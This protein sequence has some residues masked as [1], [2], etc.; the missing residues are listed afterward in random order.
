MKTK[1][2]NNSGTTRKTKVLLIRS[3][4]T[5]YIDK[6]NSVE[7]Q[8]CSQVLPPQGILHLGSYLK[9][10]GRNIAVEYLDLFLKAETAR[11]RPTSHLEL[12]DLLESHLNT[13][14]K[15][16]PPDIVGLSCNM[17]IYA[18]I[19]HLC[20]GVVKKIFPDSILVAGGHYPSTFSDEVL[21]D[22]NVDT[23]IVGEGELPFLS[24]INKYQDGQKPEKKVVNTGEFI[25]DMGSIPVL[26]Y[27]GIGIKEY[28][29]F[30][31]ERYGTEQIT[32]V[33]SRGCPNKC[34]YC[35]T[36]NVWSHKF[37][38]MSASK[39]MEEILFL[40]GKYQVNSFGFVEDN[41]ALDKL[42]VK[43]FCRMLI[44]SKLGINWYPSSIQVNCLDEEMIDLMAES[45]CS[46]LNLA[47]ESGSPRI[48]KLI[49]KNVRL[50]H[51]GKMAEHIIRRGITCECL[52]IFGFPGE[53]MED[54]QL[55]LDY[56]KSLRCDW[57]QMNI[58]TP[59]YGT[60]LYEICR[61]NGFISGGN[62]TT[63]FRQG[64]F[65]TK[66]FT[67]EQVEKFMW[68]A[69]YTLNFLKNAAFMEKNF[70]KCLKY[71]ES[72]W[73]RYPEHYICWFML[74]RNYKEHCPYCWFQANTCLNIQVP[75]TEPTTSTRG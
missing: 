29:D 31:K 10:Y 4:E 9:T 52:L 8:S 14:K 41:F 49:Q 57:Y 71:F 60:K 58:A 12:A 34:I 25:S 55:T 19:F 33:T 66:D 75:D 11:N 40:K 51:A 47:I 67:Q 21:N 5:I 22:P 53:T 43:E 45:G 54:M 26:D 74:Y 48:Q 70:K 56:A 65:S 38:S 72:L 3:P 20:V 27:E 69:N 46:K 13:I 39:V 42:R 35:A 24:L 1:S 68:S 16:S 32:L 30:H 64:S 36:H 23:V 18:P 17:N 63:V 15:D 28:I 7:Q 73:Q 62:K 44:S 59:L 6:G 50:D 37:R 2:L 61:D